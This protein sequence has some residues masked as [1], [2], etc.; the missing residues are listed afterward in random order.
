MRASISKAPSVPALCRLSKSRKGAAD[1]LKRPEEQCREEKIAGQGI[2]KRAADGIALKK[3]KPCCVSCRQPR[4]ILR[5]IRTAQPSTEIA[6]QEEK[7]RRRQ[8]GKR[9]RF[10]AER[11]A[12]PQADDPDKHKTSVHKKHPAVKSVAGHRFEKKIGEEKGRE[13]NEQAQPLTL[14][15]SSSEEGHGSYGSKVRNRNHQEAGQSHGQNHAA[16]HG[17][18]LKFRVFDRLH[19]FCCFLQN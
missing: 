9:Q 6:D 18:A 15:I 10:D 19:S 2:E 7:N 16:K 3:R 12:E 13:G 11:M 4:Q 8:H 5:I 17:H 14:K 1:P